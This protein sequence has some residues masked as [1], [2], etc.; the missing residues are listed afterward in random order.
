M[1]SIEIKFV[2]SSDVYNP[3]GMEKLRLG[4]RRGMLPYIHNCIDEAPIGIGDG[5]IDHKNFKVEG[6]IKLQ[7]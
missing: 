7:D 4:L 5:P 2:V 3:E 6:D 1:P